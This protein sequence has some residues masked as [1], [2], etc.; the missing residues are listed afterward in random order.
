VIEMGSPT[1]NRFL[2][3]I[4]VLMLLMSF[5]VGVLPSVR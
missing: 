1:V 4:V 2:V 5:V 3:L